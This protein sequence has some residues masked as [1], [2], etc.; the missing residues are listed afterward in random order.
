MQ[1]QGPR[2]TNL[3]QT[4]K[5]PDSIE[6]TFQRWTD[7]DQVLLQKTRT[8]KITK[9]GRGANVENGKPFPR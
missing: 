4:S 7:V 6:F 1:S 5:F 8:C 9:D 2:D 3:G